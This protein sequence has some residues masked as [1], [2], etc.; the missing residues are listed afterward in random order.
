MGGEKIKTT[1][2]ARTRTKAKAGPSTPLKSAPLRM[3]TL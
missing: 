2:K 1:A 3:T